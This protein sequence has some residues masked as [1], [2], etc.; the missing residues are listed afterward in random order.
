M[1]IYLQTLKYDVVRD[2]L[3]IDIFYKRRGVI[4]IEI[5]I[6]QRDLLI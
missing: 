4:W 2:I 5:E 3:Y 1:T 6:I